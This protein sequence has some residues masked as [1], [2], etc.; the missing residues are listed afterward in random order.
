MSRYS[1]RADISDSLIPAERGY[2]LRPWHQSD[3]K[4]VLEAFAPDD[5]ANQGGQWPMR[6]IEDANRWIA[7]WTHQQVQGTGYALAVQSPNGLVVG[8]V[9]VA[10]VDREHGTGF[11]SYW[12]TP[13]ARGR[14]VATIGL[15]ALALWA[16]SALDLFRLE[17][18]HRVNNPSACAVATRAGFSVE[19]MQRGKLRYEGIRYD[20]ELHAKLATDPVPDL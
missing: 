10:S 18:G 3:A 17:L 15:R 1:P 4:L 7:G 11:V 20:V 16:H 13:S 14:G 2:A 19:G 12:T 5:M 8:N 9:A 6:S